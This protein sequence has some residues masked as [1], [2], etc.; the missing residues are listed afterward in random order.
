MIKKFV[1]GI[2]LFLVCCGTSIG[3]FPQKVKDAMSR[4][5]MDTEGRV[6]AGLAQEINQEY[7][8]KVC[9]L[10]N[11]SY[12]EEITIQGYK[13]I[14]EDMCKLVDWT[15]DNIALRDSIE[16][17]PDDFLSIR[18]KQEEYLKIA[19]LSKTSKLCEI[20]IQAYCSLC[21]FLRTYEV[22]NP[23]FES[24]CEDSDEDRKTSSD[25]D[26]SGEE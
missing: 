24:S 19:E 23:S 8:Q 6:F 11:G 17:S 26:E 9:D 3:D 4:I 18:A 21:N 2:V 16:Y 22:K 20:A 5:P 1:T 15:Y 7:L 12:P 14:I 10:K 25:E 13:T